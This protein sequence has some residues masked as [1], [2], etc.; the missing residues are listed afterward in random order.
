MRKILLADDDE[1]L[2][3]LIAATLAGM[4]DHH[5][6]EARNGVE[7]LELAN[8]ERPDL[9][10]LDVNMPGIDGRRQRR[11]NSPYIMGKIFEPFFSTKRMGGRHGTGL[12]LTIIRQI[13]DDHQG[14]LDVQSEPGNGTVFS[15]YLPAFS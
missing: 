10:L 6:I 4:N 5:L 13:L 14:Y 2:R 9:I 12:G 11:R 1:A 15:V 3:I 8:A 7:A